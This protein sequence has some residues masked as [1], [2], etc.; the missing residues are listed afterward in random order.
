MEVGDIEG[1]GVNYGLVKAVKSKKTVVPPLVC[2]GPRKQPTPP[3]AADKAAHSRE[4]D[5]SQ[6]K[7][8]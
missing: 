1:G 3:G 8:K 7:K 6:H 2:R 5:C 4:S